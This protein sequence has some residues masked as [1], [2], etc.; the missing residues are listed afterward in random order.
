[1]ATKKVIWK[2]LN[3]YAKDYEVSNNGGV[4]QPIF[5]K[6]GKKIGYK[7]LS[8]NYDKYGKPRITL[9]INGTREGIRLHR[10]VAE[11]FVKKPKNAI[12]IKVLG[13][14]PIPENIEWV[15]RK[16]DKDKK[17][18]KFIYIENGKEKGI[19]MSLH[20]IARD[21]KYSYDKIKEIYEGFTKIKGVKVISL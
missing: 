4:R 5:N 1:M 14:K 20:A 8:V 12:R 9:K 3:G 6:K 7:N 17:T 21:S 16:E 19:Y 18:G 13:S 10:L 2:K 15:I 11:Q